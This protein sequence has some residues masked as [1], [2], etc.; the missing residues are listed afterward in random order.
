MTKPIY[1]LLLVIIFASCK[2]E[3]NQ[4][5]EVIVPENYTVCYDTLSL[6]EKMAYQDWEVVGGYDEIIYFNAPPSTASIY[7]EYLPF[8]YDSLS[9]VLSYLFFSDTIVLTKADSISHSIN[10]MSFGLYYQNKNDKSY[11]KWFE[12]D[13][14]YI[15]PYEMELHF[16]GLKW[17]GGEGKQTGIEPK[18]RYGVYLYLKRESILK[19][20]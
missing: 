3:I 16:V 15:N 1:F 14:F 9:P 7:E 5:P 18:K 12:L 2:K 20:K 10:N 13:V 19:C 4:T 8:S 6:K 11:T 17:Y